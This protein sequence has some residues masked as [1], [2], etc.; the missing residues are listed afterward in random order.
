MSFDHVVEFVWGMVSRHEGAKLSAVNF[1]ACT[2]GLCIAVGV[3]M[4][5]FEGTLCCGLRAWSP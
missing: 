1:T 5:I 3:P 4:A 2:V